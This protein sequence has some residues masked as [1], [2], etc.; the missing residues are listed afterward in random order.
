MSLEHYLSQAEIRPLQ[1]SLLE[2]EPAP[3]HRRMRLPLY[4]LKRVHEHIDS[5]LDGTLN[6]GTLAAVAR[7]SPSH[8]SRCF[9]NTTG[10]TPHAYVMQQRLQRARL[11]IASTSLCLTEIALRTGFA[12]QSHLTRRFNRRMGST[13]GA[14]RSQ[15]R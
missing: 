7:L 4:L 1:L 14:F 11:L 5:N 15:C 13:P 6:L 9:R 10:I 3:T 12:D 8:F 2:A